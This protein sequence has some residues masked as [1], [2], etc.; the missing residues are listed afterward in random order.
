[1]IVFLSGCAS[2]V[3]GT[4]QS[5]AVATPPADGAKCTLENSEGTWFV[6][7]PGNAQIHKTK[8]DLHITCKKDGFRDA[9]ITVAPHFNGATTGNVIA[10]GLVGLG[11]DAATGANYNYPT[12]IAVPMMSVTDAAA[13]PG[14]NCALQKLGEARFQLRPDGTWLIPAYIDG[15]DT[16]LALD[17]AGTVGTVTRKSAQDMGLSLH[18]L[19]IIETEQGVL[20]QG[21]VPGSF[22][23]AGIHSQAIPLYVSDPKAQ[24]ASGTF[25][26]NVL[27]EYD[28]ELD[29][30]AGKLTLYAP[31]NCGADAVQWTHEP[32]AVV[33]FRTNA[34]GQI[35][36]TVTL[37]GRPVDAVLDSAA[38]VSHMSPAAI[39]SFGVSP[40]G[41]SAMS[42][43]GITINTPKI[44]VTEEE[45][46]ARPYL[47]LGAST[48]RHFHIYVASNEKRLYITAASAH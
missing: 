24:A 16:L 44:T 7:S 39:K 14:A 28:Q 26:T 46:M 48:L 3:E 6:T 42:L 8:N 4:T 22:T 27:G 47:F 9:G 1:L 12:G 34:A 5:V 32:I 38:P 35:V 33:P 10:G 25:T 37:G 40:Y 20:A 2:V 17:T 31:G 43:E 41:F 30:S 36:I 29:F 23:V 45:A 11:V 18:R 15:H 19:P 13:T 21:D